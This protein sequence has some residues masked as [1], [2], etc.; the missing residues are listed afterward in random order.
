[1]RS[2]KEM[3]RDGACGGNC[4][5]CARDTVPPYEAVIEHATHLEVAIRK[6]C[7][8]I[9]T[10]DE[11]NLANDGPAGGFPPQMTLREWHTLYRTLKT[12]VKH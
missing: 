9:E 6:A 3:H 1:M 12:A 7:R 11:R 10:A 8:I 4:P 5:E 2:F